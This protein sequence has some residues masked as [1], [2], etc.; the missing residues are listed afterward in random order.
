MC[1]KCITRIKVL[2]LLGLAHLFGSANAFCLFWMP[3]KFDEQLNCA[4]CPIWAE[5]I[6][7]KL[8]GK[9]FQIISIYRKTND[10]RFNS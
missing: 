7:K 9:G 6:Q 8:I 3:W 10:E 4:D 5:R 2:F 1:Q